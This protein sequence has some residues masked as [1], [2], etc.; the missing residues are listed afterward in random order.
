LVGHQTL[1]TDS[2]ELNRIGG[3]A[4]DSYLSAWLSPW[5]SCVKL[6]RDS[7]GICTVC[8]RPAAGAVLAFCALGI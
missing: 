3:V 1:A 7:N 5:I 2:G 6:G 8:E 4:I